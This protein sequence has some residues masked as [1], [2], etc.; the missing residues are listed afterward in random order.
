MKRFIIGISGFLFLN[1]YFNGTTHF[2]SNSVIQFICLLLFF[3]IASF[4]AKINGFPGLKG[5]G[6]VKTRH[7]MR[8]FI[9]SFFIG[10]G[11]WALMY[12]AY[13]ELGKFEIIGIKTG[14]E[15]ISIIVQ[16]LVGFFLGSIINDLITRGY[17]LNLLKGKIPAYALAGISIC[18]YAVD[19]FWNGDLTTT[20][21]VFSII[22]GCSFTY[23]FLKTGSVWANT[24]IHFGLNVAYGI[25]YG[26][27]GE[28]GGGLIL[29]V[30]GEINP[31]LNNFIVLAAATIMFLA[32]F[33]YYR[34]KS[35]ENYSI[36][37][38]EQ[39]DQEARQIT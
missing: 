9:V 27:S 5:I 34:K 3:P 12:I 10:F 1:I 20:N 32:V 28:Y 2:I 18:I 21:F 22:L 36:V 13:W 39:H 11:F 37:G 7:W 24:G 31:I 35:D 17:V 23:S 29:T 38:V 4:V 16:V 26:L 25:I 6:L 15:A 30:K 19:D 14:I 8:H 33:L